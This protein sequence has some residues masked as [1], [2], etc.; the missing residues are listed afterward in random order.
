M[1]EQELRDDEK[2]WDE[3]DA[4][5]EV[6]AQAERKY[7]ESLTDEEYYRQYVLPYQCVEE[8]TIYE[9]SIEVI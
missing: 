3:L 1:T 8:D 9:Q 6:E 2:F 5:L 4:E 7:I